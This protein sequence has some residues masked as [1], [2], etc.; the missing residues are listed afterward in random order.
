MKTFFISETTRICESYRH[1]NSNAANVLLGESVNNNNLA[2]L[3]PIE[4]MKAHLEVVDCK[5]ENFSEEDE[6]EVIVSNLEDPKDVGFDEEEDEDM[7]SPNLQRKNVGFF[8]KNEKK[9]GICNFWKSEPLFDIEELEK[10]QMTPTSTIVD[11]LNNKDNK[12]TPLNLQKVDLNLV[13]LDDENEKNDKSPNFPKNKVFSQSEVFKN[14]KG[15]AVESTTNN[16]N[17]PPQKNLGLC[18]SQTLAHQGIFNPHESETEEF[19]KAE[20]EAKMRYQLFKKIRELKELELQLFSKFE[21]EYL[22][23]K[24]A[25]KQKKRKTVVYKEDIKENDLTKSTSNFNGPVMPLAS[26]SCLD[27]KKKKI[28]ERENSGKFA[29]AKNMNFHH[30]RTISNQSVN[31]LKIGENLGHKRSNSNNSQ[32]SLKTEKNQ[33]NLSNYQNLHKRTQ[34]NFSSTTAN[35]ENDGSFT[36]QQKN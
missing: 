1:T 25:I 5:S 18:K 2:I 30:K 27:F 26:Q 24:K 20:E 35:N 6:K 32:K 10:S 36:G 22:V 19:L 12:K 34:S 17:S 29:G 11:V 14:H 4:E 23:K 9:G 33:G 7:E 13:D 8:N 3:N 21:T 31:L 16:T 15:L 28:V